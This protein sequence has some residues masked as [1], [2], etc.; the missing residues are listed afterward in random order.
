[1][2][3]KTCLLIVLSTGVIQAKG[4][5]KILL[6]GEDQIKIISQ[7]PRPTG[8]K[9]QLKLSLEDETAGIEK[10]LLKAGSLTELIVLEKFKW[11]RVI[12]VVSGDLQMIH[13]VTE[14]NR[15]SCVVC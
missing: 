12:Y 11:N 10:T 2:Y 5:V 4:N 6:K 7:D 1:M 13:S 14:S 8:T 15:G 9:N 3:L